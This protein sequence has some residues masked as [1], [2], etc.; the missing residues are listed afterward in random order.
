[1]RNREGFGGE[2][3]P[4]EGVESRVVLEFFRHGKKE[5]DP[6]KANKDLQL[7]LEGR[8]QGRQ[9][10]ESIKPQPEVS[11]A[12]GS[13]RARTR[14]TALRVM[15]SESDDITDEMTMD[16]IEQ[17][18]SEELGGNLRK[19]IEVEGLDYEG[20]NS[21]LPDEGR[22]WSSEGKYMKWVLERSDDI[23]A[24]L[25]DDG[26]YTAGGNSEAIA[27]IIQK[28]LKVGDT[29]SRIV[30]K[31]KSKYEE[32]ANQLERYFGTHQAVQESFLAKY[33]ELAQGDEARQRFVELIGDS[34]FDELDGMRIEITNKNGEQSAHLSAE[35]KG[36]KIEFDIDPDILEQ[37]AKR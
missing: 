34:G 2:F 5:S 33:L 20:K 18:I 19:V 7:T 37:I 12:G 16:E 15:L 17:K 10:G 22:E 28:Y 24:E 32:F 4:K 14:D 8:Q 30:E 1:M 11:I 31:D 21:P 6:E 25:G 29:F 3:E 26:G 23:S 35:V 36:E 13:P 9:K 27:K